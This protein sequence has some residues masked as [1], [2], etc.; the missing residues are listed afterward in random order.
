MHLSLQ[1]GWTALMMASQAAHMECVKLLLDRCAKVN[2]QNN[3]SDV[4]IHCVHAMQ[5]VSRVPSS[6][7]ST[8]VCWSGYRRMEL[9]WR[10]RPMYFRAW[11]FVFN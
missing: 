9:V 5:H 2:M 7:N 10:P 3:V 11:E 8:L 4:I 1:D 6:G